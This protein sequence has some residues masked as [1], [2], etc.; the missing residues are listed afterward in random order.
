MRV[1]APVV[2]DPKGQAVDELKA[3]GLALAGLY[4]TT[5]RNQGGGD[6]FDK[7]RGAGQAGKGRVQMGTDLLQIEMLEGTVV[8]AMEQDQ[9]G[10]D[11][12]QGQA[13]G[14]VALF[15][16]GSNQV[17]APH[18]LKAGTEVVDVAEN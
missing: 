15:A 8:Q 5:E 2:T 18:R 4:V 6:Q 17:L 13:A 16:G 7:A 9:N 11:F 1:D 14:A 12:P 10:H 3:G